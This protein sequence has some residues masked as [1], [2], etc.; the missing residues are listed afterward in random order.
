MKLNKRDQYQNRVIYAVLS[1]ESVNHNIDLSNVVV[2]QNGA[3]ADHFELSDDHMV[4][5]FRTVG[6]DDA[7]LYRLPQGEYY[8]TESIVPEGYAKAD[9]ITFTVNEYGSLEYV[10]VKGTPQEIFDREVLMLDKADP[11]ADQPDQPY[12][13]ATGED[14]SVV[15]SL[16]AACLVI[17]GGVAVFA[18]RRSKKNE[19]Q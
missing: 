7:Y 19:E 1:I 10:Y 18:F 4:I 6:A 12:I 3:P 5:S 9:R 17:S 2:L 11:S 16:A 8:I 13:P 14:V 15:V